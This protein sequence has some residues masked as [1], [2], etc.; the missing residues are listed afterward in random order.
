MI[1]FKNT[2]L[3][4]EFGSTRIKGVL[5]DFDGH[6]LASGSHEWENKLIDGVWTYDLADVDAGLK[7]CYASLR[8]DIE[9][10][11]KNTPKTF[12]AIGISAMMHGYLAFDENDNL[13]V[14]FRTWRNSTAANAA[15]KLTEVLGDLIEKPAGKPKLAPE[16]DPREA[17]NSVA[18]AAKDFKEE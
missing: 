9:S 6:V 14:P 10:K 1:D 12:G 13:L 2:A 11:Y 18:E 16:S 5:I 15:K 7:S 4:I 8:K 3:G 17:I